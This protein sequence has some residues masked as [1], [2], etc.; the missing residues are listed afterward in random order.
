MSPKKLTSLLPP[1]RAAKRELGVNVRFTQEEYDALESVATYRDI[2][3][4]ELIYHV[5]AQFAIPQLREE[6]E[7]EIAASKQVAP[8]GADLHLPSNSTQAVDLSSHQPE[9][10]PSPTDLKNTQGNMIRSG[11]KP[12]RLLGNGTSVESST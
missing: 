7:A 4:T 10:L 12:S 9:L 5:V 6:I 3:I 8:D 1:K 11:N 2:T